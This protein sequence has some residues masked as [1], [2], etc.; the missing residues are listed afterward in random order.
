MAT[1]PKSL[2]IRKL[3]SCVMERPLWCHSTFIVASL[4]G[5]KEA[6]KWADWPSLMLKLRNGRLKDGL[7]VKTESTSSGR[8]KA[9]VADSKHWILPKAVWW[10]G[11][12]V[13][14]PDRDETSIWMDEEEVPNV[15]L[16]GANKID[17]RSRYPEARAAKP[18]P[19]SLTVTAR[20]RLTINAP[21]N[22]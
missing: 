10:K 22:L 16:Y 15:V 20:E 6:S 2:V 17:A 4:N 3:C 1:K 18:K 5:T 12:I 9:G 8:Q 11:R 13:I 19:K 7:S 21:L 14:R